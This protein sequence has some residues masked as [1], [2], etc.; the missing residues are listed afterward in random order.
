MGLL[1]D[2]EMR[3]YPEADSPMPH[4]GIE[5]IAK[6]LDEKYSILSQEREELLMRIDASQ[7]R[8]R[9][10]DTMRAMIESAMSEYKNAHSKVQMTGG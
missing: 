9:E 8:V 2:E 10:I 3:A 7:N 1:R 6:D 5:Y 4:I